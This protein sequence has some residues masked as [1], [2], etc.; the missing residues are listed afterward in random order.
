MKYM[1]AEHDND[2]YVYAI[3]NNGF[4]EGKQNHIA[5]D[6]IKNW[7]LR[8]G[9]HFAQGIGHGAGE[10]MEYLKKYPL[11]YGPLKSLGKSLIHISENIQTNSSGETVFSNPNFP[12]F[13]WKFAGT[14]FF[15]NDSAK[16]NSVKKKEILKRL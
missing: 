8:C 11:G 15:W 10:M 16:K 3:V 1:K 5:I 4:Y 14:H 13:A 2:I 12:R 7:S 6:I 9:I